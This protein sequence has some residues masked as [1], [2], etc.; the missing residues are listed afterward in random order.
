MSYKN[1]INKFASA[2]AIQAAIDNG[3]LLKPYVAL[4]AS[5]GTLDWNSKNITPDP[6]EGYSSQEECECVEGGGYWDGSEC[7]YP[8]DCAAEWQ[9]R[10]YESYEDCR[11]AEYGECPEPP[12]PT[13]GE[14][15]DETHFTVTETNPSYWTE[16]AYVGNTKYGVWYTEDNWQTITGP[17][18]LPI[19]YGYFSPGETNWGFQ[20]GDFTNVLDDGP[21]LHFD[22]I[23]TT[24]PD[25]EISRVRI[26]PNSFQNPTVW[27]FRNI[28][29]NGVNPSY[30]DSPSESGSDS[31]S[32]SGSGSESGSGSGSGSSQ[33]DDPTPVEPD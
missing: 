9:E 1:H 16:G 2:A 33:L 26:E 22:Y 23:S 30:P 20:I 11:C 18:I 25:E 15:T 10:G 14:W 4:D 21:W 19:K 24:D 27:D 6:C 29:V 7:I 17:V 8:V 12:V 31:E 3:D 5:A 13:M 32:G 28:P